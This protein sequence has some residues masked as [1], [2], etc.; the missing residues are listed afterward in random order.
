ME[1]GENAGVDDVEDRVDERHADHAHRRIHKAEADDR[2]RTVEQ[3]H[4]DDRA[5]DLD[6][7]MDDRDLLGLLRDADGGDQGGHAGA[8]VRA[9][10]Q[11]MAMV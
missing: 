9:E 4:A 7:H 2:R 6:R 8:D 11:R 1:R 5:D 10:H 3:T